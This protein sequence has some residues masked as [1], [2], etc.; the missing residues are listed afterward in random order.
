MYLGFFL[1]LTGWAIFLSNASTFP[2]LPLFVLY[3]NRFQIAP[4]ERE[5]L[6]KFGSEYSAYKDAVRRWL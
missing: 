1:M 6:S 2:F 3:L 4:E 5:L